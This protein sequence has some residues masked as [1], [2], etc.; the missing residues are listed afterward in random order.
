[1]INGTFKQVGDSV[2]EICG[3]LVIGL[4]WSFHVFVIYE[5]DISLLE[6]ASD[7]VKSFNLEE[8]EI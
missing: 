2:V 5:K 8:L 7:L 3:D 6:T 1:V 4:R